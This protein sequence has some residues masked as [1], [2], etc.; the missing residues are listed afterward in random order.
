MTSNNV[1]SVRLLLKI[2]SSMKQHLTWIGRFVL[3][4]TAVVQIGYIGVLIIHV[5]NKNVFQTHSNKYFIYR[6]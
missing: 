3:V 6:M 2:S 1:K 4:I 5:E